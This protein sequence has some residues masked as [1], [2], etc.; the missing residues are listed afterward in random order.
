MYGARV[1]G[2]R[3]ITAPVSAH[4]RPKLHPNSRAIKADWA[5]DV[6]LLVRDKSL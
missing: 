6:R 2:T 1:Y 5:L 3:A 4:L